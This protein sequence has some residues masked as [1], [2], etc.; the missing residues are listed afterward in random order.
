MLMISTCHQI[1]PTNHHACRPLL[2]NP[3]SCIISRKIH[4]YLPVI[5]QPTT[6]FSSASLQPLSAYLLISLWWLGGFFSL[7]RDGQKKRHNGETCLEHYVLH[8]LVLETRRSLT[9][10]N[11]NQWFQRVIHVILGLTFGLLWSTRSMSLESRKGKNLWRLVGNR[12]E[13]Y[14]SGGGFAFYFP[15]PERSR[16]SVL[17]LFGVLSWLR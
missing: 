5:M 2:S 4:Q 14:Y 16:G 6:S 7:L 3:L 9:V 15:R 1:S 12:K 10:L 17:S 8:F 11:K 13:L